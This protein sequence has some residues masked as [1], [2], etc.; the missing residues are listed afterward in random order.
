MYKNEKDDDEYD[1]YMKEFDKIKNSNNEIMMYMSVLAKLIV[2]SGNVELDSLEDQLIA[3]V[4][5]GVQDREGYKKIK[6]VEI[7]N[8]Q[9]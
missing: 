9:V 5:I 8:N 1:V 6:Q 3:S 4:L 7:L 2:K